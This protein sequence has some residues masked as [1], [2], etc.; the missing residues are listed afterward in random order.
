MED[1]HNHEMEQPLTMQEWQELLRVD[2]R[3]AG[4][5][6]LHQVSLASEDSSAL[7]RSIALFQYCT[8]RQP[9]QYLKR[10]LELAQHLVERPLD[11]PISH[12]HVVLRE[13]QG[14]PYLDFVSPTTLLHHVDSLWRI[15]ASQCQVSNVSFLHTLRRFPKPADTVTFR[16]F[17][18]DYLSPKTQHGRAKINTF[19]Q[20]LQRTIPS[21]IAR[22]AI[23]LEEHAHG[24]LSDD[25]QPGDFSS[26]LLPYPNETMWQELLARDGAAARQHFYTL[27]LIQ[28]QVGLSLSFHLG[29]SLAAYCALTQ[30][31]H[32]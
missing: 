27:K 25:V 8:R 2:G 28:A 18:E 30:L 26:L 17:V 21:L 4:R 29:E 19:D 3:R 15:V 14:N 10:A 11:A 22:L 5:R 31:G 32:Q 23:I 6:Y 16:N 13:S 9:H 1:V 12:Q 20:R 24:E 7:H